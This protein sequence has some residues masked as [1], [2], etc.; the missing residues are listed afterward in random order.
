VRFFCIDLRPDIDLTAIG[1]RQC[2]AAEGNGGASPP[3][4]FTRRLFC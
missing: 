3:H 2:A 1:A 4:E